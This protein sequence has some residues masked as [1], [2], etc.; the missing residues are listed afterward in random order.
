MEEIVV[1]FLLFDH[2]PFLWG[3][4]KLMRNIIQYSM[5]YAVNEC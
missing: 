4:Q 5:Q 2:I 1:V 3:W